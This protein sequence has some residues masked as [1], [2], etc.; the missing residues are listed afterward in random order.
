MHRYRQGSERQREIDNVKEEEKYLQSK[1]SISIALLPFCT[2]ILFL[3]STET[4]GQRG[5][6]VRHS[7]RMSACL[8]TS[9]A[10][11]QLAR[12]G[13]GMQVRDRDVFQASV[14]EVA[15]KI[16]NIAAAAVAIVSR[17]SAHDHLQ[18][19]PVAV[20]AL[21]GLLLLRFCLQMGERRREGALLAGKEGR[22]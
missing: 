10:M 8:F 5:C 14:K 15:M 21:E 4:N 2:L 19:L 22:K 7:R 12:E 17:F 6:G 13:R 16:T 3:D 1:V 11:R 20:I 18:H 9:V